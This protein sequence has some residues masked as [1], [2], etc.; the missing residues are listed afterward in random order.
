MSNALKAASD[1]RKLAKL[2]ESMADAADALDQIGSLEQAENEAQVRLD[3]INEELRHQRALREAAELETS[4]MLAVAQAKA[5]QIMASAVDSA[6]ELQRQAQ[7]MLA[8][9]RAESALIVEAS[10]QR[11]AE[12]KQQADAAEDRVVSAL[13]EVTE[14][15]KRAEK[16]R[17]Y[18]F[19]LVG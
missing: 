10:Q 5:D 9:S 6:A 11:A 12:L 3:K 4:D 1:I 7:E 14:L 2:Y 18:L 19:K 17:A 15:E 13:A 16:A 8:K